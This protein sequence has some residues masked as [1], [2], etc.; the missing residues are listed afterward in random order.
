M[1]SLTDLFP[2]SD[3]VTGAAAG[4]LE[5]IYVYNSNL[6]TASNG[7]SCCLWTV[8]DNVTWANFEV[9]GGGGRGPGGCCCQQ[10]K[11]SGG[12]GAYGRKTISVTPGDSYTVCAAG[13]TDCNCSCCGTEGFPSFV[14]DNDVSGNS[15]DVCVKGG[16][17][18][19]GKC[20]V[21]YGTCNFQGF[22][23]NCRSEG[24]QGV[25][26]GLPRISG[27]HRS[28]WCHRG[29]FSHTPQ[30]PNFGGGALTSADSCSRQGSGCCMYCSF[31][32]FP[33]GGGP[34]AHTSSD[35]RCWGMFGAGGLV[36]ITY[37]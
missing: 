19:C 14:V 7:G 8:P 12:A 32:A 20:F 11:H 16:P 28:M 3:Y 25:D 10:P 13:T 24:F 4:Q 21:L 37:R 22:T 33:A 9:W 30:G 36:I 29:S 26:F 15:L 6:T 35:G 18:S 17:R 31:A 34:G 23:I 5:R 1:A 2:I 27:A